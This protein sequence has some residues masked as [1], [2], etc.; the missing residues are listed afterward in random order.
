MMRRI[1]ITPPKIEENEQFSIMEMLRLGAERVH[2][3]KPGISEDEMRNLIESIPVIGRKNIS[4]HEH[5][6]LAAQSGIGGVH[7]NSRFPDI[8]DDFQG[9]VSRSCHSIYELQ[10][11]MDFDYVFI[12]PVFDSIS[13]PDYKSAFSP[14][15]IYEAVQKEWLD[16]RVFALGGV[17]PGRFADI[18][19]MGFGGA[20]MLGAAW[21]PVLSRGEAWRLQYIT[22]P[23][24][25]KVEILRG[26]LGALQ[27]GCRWIQLRMKD[28]TARRII[29]T[30][31]SV[32]ALCRKYKAVFILDDRVDLVYASRA[33]GV[34]LG[35]N[36]MS[37][38][39]ARSILGV[40]Y[41]IGATANTARDID[42]AC[43]AGVDYIGV[44]PLRFTST[45][46]NLAPVLGY[47]GYKEI[48][49]KRNSYPPI[50]AIGG[51]VPDDIKPLAEAGISGIAVS[52][53]IAG[54]PNPAEMT[55]CFLNR[56]SEII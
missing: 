10:E 38:A 9:L 33:D 54:A 19:A 4:I 7:L 31:L 55:Q 44:G 2:I 43:E 3:R 52:G 47:N 51:I 37:A 30:A 12:S 22:P 17:H 26:V 1:V 29:D 13:K 34:H 42:I 49:Q 50:V 18:E 6:H 56:F 24:A 27:G 8:P 41:I 25:N 32:S 14:A 21:R 46:Q 11:C 40:G 5:L 16:K 28:A 45:K 20:A 15:D 48:C 39:L 35:K 53:A 23:A 36:D